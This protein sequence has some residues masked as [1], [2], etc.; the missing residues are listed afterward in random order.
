M[1]NPYALL[2]AGV[3]WLISLALCFWLAYSRGHDDMRNAYTEQQLSTANAN[4]KASQQNQDKA[5][6]AGASHEANVQT[7]HDTTREIVR[8]VT[9]PPDRDP[10]LPV[11]FVR[12]FDRSASRSINGDPYPGKSDGDPSDVRVSE[13]ATLLSRESGWADKY[14]ACRQQVADIVA[15]NPVLPTP[16]QSNPSL[17]ERIFN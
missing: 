1:P 2:G 4:L 10:Y 5:A 7:V 6:K 13:A 14:Y 16:P 3:A 17:I 9:I 12:L 11:G 8:T 15:L